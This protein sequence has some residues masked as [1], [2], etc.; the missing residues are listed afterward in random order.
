M[1]FVLIQFLK[2]FLTGSTPNYNT[3]WIFF[4]GRNSAL[5]HFS[6]L[7]TTTKRKQWPGAQV[8]ARSLLLLLHQPLLLLSGAFPQHGDRTISCNRPRQCLPRG[9][10]GYIFLAHI[11]FHVF[12]GLLVCFYIS[13]CINYNL[14]L[15]H[16]INYIWN[17][18]S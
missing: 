14:F 15:H 6:D 11:C 8:Q 9:V 5:V 2:Y 13:I 17:V 1:S 18:Q 7:V 10:V 16:S 4:K 12:V 3:V